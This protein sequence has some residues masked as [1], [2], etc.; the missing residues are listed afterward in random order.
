MTPKQRKKRFAALAQI[1]CIVCRNE[2]LGDTPAEIHHLKGY[3]YSSMGKRASDQVSIPLC[4]IH[5]RHGGHGQVGYHQSPD[6]FES[7]YGTQAELLDQVN[8]IIDSM[9]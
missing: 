2:G 3:Q 5:H 8:G 9:D 1:G 4:P 7:R 6:R